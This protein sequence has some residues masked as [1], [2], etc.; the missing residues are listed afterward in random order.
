MLPPAVPPQYCG[1][2][3]NAEYPAAVP[4]A[5]LPRFH[6]PLPS[7]LVGSA[8]LCTIRR[9]VCRCISHVARRPMRLSRTRVR[10]RRDRRGHHDDARPNGEYVRTDPA[11]PA[12]SAQDPA[13]STRR[14]SV[15]AQCAT[16][17]GLPVPTARNG[18]CAIA[19]LDRVAR[20]MSAGRAS[21]C[22]LRCAAEE[23]DGFAVIDSEGFGSAA[24][25][26]DA[27]STVADAQSQVSS[28]PCRLLYF[29]RCMLGVVR[30]MLPVVMLP[31]GIHRHGRAVAG[32]R[33]RA[34][35]VTARGTHSRSCGVH[36]VQRSH[37]GMQRPC[38]CDRSA[39][40]DG[41][42]VGHVEV[43]GR[44]PI[45]APKEHGR[46]S[47][48]S[49]AGAGQSEECWA[50]P[51]H[52]CTTTGLALATSAR[53]W[54]HGRHIGSKTGLTPSTSAQRSVAT[55]G[56]AGCGPGGFRNQSETAAALD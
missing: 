56:R 13:A 36:A 7:A 39:C 27:A 45:Y 21:A 49:G 5:T 6:A 33:Q 19:T 48:G 29:V 44:A 34:A 4:Q 38:L 25:F 2:L 22:M 3:T 18:P 55:V 37:A 35:C 30:W 47:D 31:V 52:I 53:D 54:A 10:H 15:G 23:A 14:A 9:V 50:H 40:S 43:D 8:L 41:S 26:D 28:V 51:C 24:V 20:C 17:P 42:R 11:N 46:G 16:G 12:T 1:V 32:V